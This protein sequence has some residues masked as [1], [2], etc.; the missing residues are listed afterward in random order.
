MT[1]RA[2]R[3]PF[4]L[5]LLIAEAKRRARRRDFLLASMLV[6]TAVGT[7]IAVISTRSPAGTNTSHPAARWQGT[8]TC[9]NGGMAI[10]PAMQ[11]VGI[12][13]AGMR[14]SM[15]FATANSIAQ[16][17]GPQELQPAGTHSGTAQTVPCNVAGNAA[18]V[19]ANTWSIGHQ[20]QFAIKA[21]WV[22]YA[23]GPVFRFHCVLRSE[24]G[25]TLVGTCLHKAN[26]Q[27]G[28]VKV[29]FQIHRVAETS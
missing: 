27:A 18:D 8:Q 26:G 28:A 19:A 10:M 2:P 12:V 25:R 13:S 24:A 9:H 5:D 6:L 21:G 11:V 23:V 17:T 7:A 14:V 3:L 1:A 4:S 29:R 20:Q 22:G 15:S 16:R